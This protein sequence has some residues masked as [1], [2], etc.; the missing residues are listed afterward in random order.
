[1]TCNGTVYVL[2]DEGMQ[3][4]SLSYVQ[5]SRSRVSTQIFSTKE[6]AG[7]DLALLSKKMSRE[8]L[9]RMASDLKPEVSD[10]RHEPEK[11]QISQGL[12]IS[13]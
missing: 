9:K 6:E 4:R 8:R 10:Q 2:T 3:D 1:M 5:A 11:P 7:A 12:E 13:L